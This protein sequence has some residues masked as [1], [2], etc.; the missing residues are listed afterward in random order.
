MVKKK[1]TDHSVRATGI[2]AFEKDGVLHHKMACPYCRKTLV[3]RVDS[4]Y[5]PKG[6]T[7]KCP[8]CRRVFRK[9]ERPVKKERKG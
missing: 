8:G 2:N 6:S 9:F 5:Y 3:F 4:N 1:I 7:M